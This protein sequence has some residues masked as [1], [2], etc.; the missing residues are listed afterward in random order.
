LAKAHE[1]HQPNCFKAVSEGVRQWL[2]QFDWDGV[3]PRKAVFRV[4]G[5]DQQSVAVYADE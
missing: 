5:G 2:E 1:A 4:V 3:E